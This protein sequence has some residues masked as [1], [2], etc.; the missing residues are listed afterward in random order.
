MIICDLCKRECLDDR[1]VEIHY[2]FACRAYQSKEVHL[3][4][5]CKEE[6]K[7]TKIQA[8]VEFYQRKV[9]ETAEETKETVEKL[10]TPEDV[11]RMTRSEVKE[12][13]NAILKSMETWH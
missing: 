12:N 11:C 4:G 5:R 1:K 10:F 2:D 3:C 9:A 7:K 8:E 13:Y 6:L